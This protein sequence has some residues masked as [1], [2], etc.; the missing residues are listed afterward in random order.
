MLVA[1][2]AAERDLLDQADLVP[3]QPA[4]A[5]DQG[6]E[7]VRIGQVG[8]VGDLAGHIP[9]VGAGLRLSD[10]VGRAGRQFGYR[11]GDDPDVLHVGAVLEVRA[12][13]QPPDGEAQP[14]EAAQPGEGTAALPRPRA[15]PPPSRFLRSSLTACHSAPAVAPASS[16]TA[17]QAKSFR[18]SH[19]TT[20]V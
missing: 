3:G 8:D 18:S 4:A 13:H 15:R 2:V 1:A 11:L 14:Q 19:T 10:Q 9:Q 17:S 5:F 12:V 7:P 20:V 16:G 6:R